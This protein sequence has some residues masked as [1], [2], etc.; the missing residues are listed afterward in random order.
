MF[1]AVVANDLE[2]SGSVLA[3]SSFFCSTLR[4][5]L[6]CHQI[7]LVKDLLLFFC[8]KK[9]LLA[10]HAYGFNIGHRTNLPASLLNSVCKNIT[11]LETVS[12]TR[13][14]LNM[15]TDS[16]AQRV[17]IVTALQARDDASTAYLLGPLDYRP[18]HRN[19]IRIFKLQL[20]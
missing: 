18:R 12:R 7:P 9:C 5:P 20:T 10:L 14:C 19:V 3:G 11:Q 16:L 4:A 6:R 1:S 2:A 8:K 17:Q 13:K 15:R